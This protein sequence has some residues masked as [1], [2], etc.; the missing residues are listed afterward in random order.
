MGTQQRAEEDVAEPALRKVHD[1]GE[2]RLR[3]PGFFGLEVASTCLRR[4]ASA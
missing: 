1:L 4:A 2:Q 3:F